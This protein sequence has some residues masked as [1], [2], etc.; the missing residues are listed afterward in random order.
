[1]YPLVASLFL[2]QKGIE[3]IVIPNPVTKMEM[4]HMGAL[5]EKIKREGGRLHQ[6]VQCQIH[7]FFF[8]TRTVHFSLISLKV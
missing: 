3:I 2:M 5:V 6:T 8:P 7:R 4:S 1:M